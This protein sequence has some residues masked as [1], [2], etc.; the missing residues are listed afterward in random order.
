MAKEKRVQQME[1]KS[2]TQEEAKAYRAALYVPQTVKLTEQQ[3]REQ[4]RLFW[5]LAKRKYGKTAKD[6]EEIV[7]LHLKSSKMTDPSQ[8]EAG[9]VH[10]GLKKI[11]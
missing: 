1:N 3:K 6:L 10:F 2:M 11:S 5:A 9:I 8:F 4:F 7:W